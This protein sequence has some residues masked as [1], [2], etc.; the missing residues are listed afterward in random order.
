M[1][2]HYHVFIDFQKNDTLCHYC[3][4]WQ[5]VFK[6]P[7]E[8][9]L[10]VTIRINRFLPGVSWIS[11]NKFST[12]LRL[13]AINIIH[14]KFS[15]CVCYVGISYGSYRRVSLRIRTV[16]D[17]IGRVNNWPSRVYIIH[18]QMEYRDY[19]IEWFV[20]K[21]SHFCSSVACSNAGLD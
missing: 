13:M 6:I 5:R 17:N 10:A 8:F 18:R 11:G 16:R 4:V 20:Q 15:N 21:K 14:L 1:C 9:L 7:E 2:L 12:C 19:R 3:E